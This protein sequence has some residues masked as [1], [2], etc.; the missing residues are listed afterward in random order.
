[1]CRN[2]SVVAKLFKVNIVLLVWSYKY[3]FAIKAHNA[4]ISQLPVQFIY[5][6]W[7]P[8]EAGTL[9]QIDKLMRGTPL[10]PVEK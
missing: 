10:R 1:M 6:R 2:V 8:V 7:G 5:G 3:K 4:F 9:L